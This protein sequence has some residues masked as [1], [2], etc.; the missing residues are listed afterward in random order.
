MNSPFRGPK[1]ETSTSPGY[2]LGAIAF[3]WLMAALV[4]V[5]GGVG[6]LFKY[7]PRKA[8]PEWLSVHALFGLAVLV[9]VVARMRWR[10]TH[11]PPDLP[12]QIGEFTRRT[13]HAAHILLYVLMFITPIMGIVGFIAHGRVLYLGLFSLHSPA[14]NRAIFHP[15][16]HIHQWLA[17]GLF[18]LAGIHIAAALWHHFILRDG[19]I[20]RI[21]P[22]RKRA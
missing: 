18:A 4:V 6:L 7:F 13:S 10:A 2:G 1:A 17:Y 15:A 8:F 14:P 5:V 12:G 9:L 21:L 19:L 16:E 3:H 20:L 11:V 22:A